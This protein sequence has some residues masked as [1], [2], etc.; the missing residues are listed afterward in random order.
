MS[1][2]PSPWTSKSGSGRS[3]KRPSRP[4]LC[5]TSSPCVNPPTEVRLCL[6]LLCSSPTRPGADFFWLGH[7][8]CRT[9]LLVGMVV[10]IQVYDKRAIYTSQSHP[11]SPSLML[12]ISPVDDGTAVIDCVL[13]HPHPTLPAP[14][15]RSPPRST[16]GPGKPVPKRP[17]PKKPR[18]DK[19][20]LESTEPP[21]PITE[22][23]YPVRVVG[24]VAR[25]YQSKQIHADTIGVFSFRLFYHALLMHPHRPLSFLGRRN[26]T[27][28]TRHRAP[29]DKVLHRCPFRSTSQTHPAHPS[30]RY[31]DRSRCE[32]L[33][34]YVAPFTPGSR[35]RF[36][37]PSSS[38]THAAA[39]SESESISIRTD[40]SPLRVSRSHA[41][42]LLAH[43]V[44]HGILD[45]F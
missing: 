2:A 31:I 37:C 10:G 24:R 1:R 35:H 3:P 44:V 28:G 15:P 22:P 13:R 18:L 41:R 5:V 42:P 16:G 19:A 43:G 17:S 12:T 9:V 11:R 36:V 8:P 6:A 26:R 23:G 45:A 33:L 32:R 29:Q 21:P 40:T 30:A 25:H 39:A 38:S 4:A 20:Q 14:A 27:P 34:Q 7:T